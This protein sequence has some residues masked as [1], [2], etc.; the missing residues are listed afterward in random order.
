MTRRDGSRLLRLLGFAD[1]F[2][3]VWVEVKAVY[4]FDF[5]LVDL[6]R[7]NEVILAEPVDRVRPNFD[8]DVAVA[9]KMQVRMM[10][11]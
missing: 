11:F 1:T 8:S 7:K 10:G 6:G 3:G 9:F 2:M 5:N 4:L